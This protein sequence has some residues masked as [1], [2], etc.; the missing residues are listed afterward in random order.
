MRDHD[1]TRE[2]ACAPRQELAG[3]LPQGLIY[4]PRGRECTRAD[5]PGEPDGILAEDGT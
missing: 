4:V 3:V 2:Q 1:G 5:V